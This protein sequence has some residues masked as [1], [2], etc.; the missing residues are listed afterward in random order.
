M[1]HEQQ[2]LSIQ[3]EDPVRIQMYR[4]R[5]GDTEYADGLATSFCSPLKGAASSQ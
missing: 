1:L 2:F 4:H 3:P 5:Y